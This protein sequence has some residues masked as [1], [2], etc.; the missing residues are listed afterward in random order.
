MKKEIS[1]PSILLRLAIWLGVAAVLFITA[2]VLLSDYQRVLQLI[3]SISPLWLAMIIGAVL[4]NYALRFAKWNFFLHVLKIRLPW[5]LNLWVFFSAFT[6]VLSPAKLGELVKSFL[7]KARLGIP[8]SATAPIVM[9]ERLTDLIG[10]LILCALGFTQFA[11]GG[12]TLLL[13]GG[14]I[15]IGTLVITRPEFWGIIDRGLGLHPALSRFRGAVKAIQHSTS[16]LLSFKALLLTVPLSAISWAGEGV[17]LYLIFRAMGLDMPN[18]PAI[19]IFAHAFGSVAGALS[20]LPGGLLV[21]EGAMGMFFV[22]AAVPDAT[23][24][25]A[26]FLIRA[27]TLWFAVILGTIVFIAG[28]QKSDLLAFQPAAESSSDSG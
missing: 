12:N 14:L 9:A 11:F 1:I 7:L 22:Y 13:A 17:A 28:H 18:L 10:L 16:T 25:S 23:A 8:V 15:V 5:R 27:M 4:F 19:A 26:T 24:V 21:T 20:F 2:I 3:A 6:M